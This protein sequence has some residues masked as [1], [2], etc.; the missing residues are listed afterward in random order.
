LDISKNKCLQRQQRFVEW[1]AKYCTAN[2]A[3]DLQT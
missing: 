2:Q 3:G 1:G